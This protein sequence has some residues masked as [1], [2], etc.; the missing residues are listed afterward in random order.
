MIPISLS[1][2]R[3]VS[4]RKWLYL[5]IDQSIGLADKFKLFCWTLDKSDDPF[6]V[7][8]AQSETVGDLKN[9]I[10]SDDPELDY[11]A[12]KSLTLFKVSNSFLP[13]VWLIMTRQCF[14]L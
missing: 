3:A 12:A 10:R 11:L 2:P 8:I 5:S 1:Y 4:N 13:R 9:K 6:P 7:D 14:T